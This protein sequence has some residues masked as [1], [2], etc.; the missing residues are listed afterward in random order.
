MSAIKKSYKGGDSAAKP[1]VGKGG[2][3]T[4]VP[5]MAGNGPAK[6]SWTGAKK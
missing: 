3:P 2:H 6:M 5:G 1:S 4:Q